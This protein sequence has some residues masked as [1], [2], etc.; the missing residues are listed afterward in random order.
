MSGFDR[1]LLPP[2]GWVAQLKDEDRELLASYGEFQGIHPDHDMIRQGEPQEHVY[3]VISGKLEVRKQGLDDD[4]IVGVIQAHESI[5]DLGIFDPAPAS[6]SVRALEFSQVWRIGRDNL[7]GFIQ[8]SP[9]A[10]NTILLGICEIL[11]KRLREANA[12]FVDAKIGFHR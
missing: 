11:S 6:A 3:F 8:D 9:V 12:Q 7:L 5:G 10:G 1:P 2:A 4:I